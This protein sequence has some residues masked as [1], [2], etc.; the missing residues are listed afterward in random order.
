MRTWEEEENRHQRYV[1]FT[2]LPRPHAWLPHM[3]F[4]SLMPQR[5]PICRNIFKTFEVQAARNIF[6][7]GAFDLLNHMALEVGVFR[8]ATH[9]RGE[10][11][12]TGSRRPRGPGVCC[13][14]MDKDHLGLDQIRNHFPHP[15]RKRSVL[16]LG[17]QTPPKDPQRFPPV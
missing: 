6:K 7:T 3:C 5:L 9:D 8:C 11:C 16:F 12:E 14:H 4:T 15:H 10:Q 1:P 13:T 17:I 2:A